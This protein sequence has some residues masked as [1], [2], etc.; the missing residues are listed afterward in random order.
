MKRWYYGVTVVVS[1]LA[2]FIVFWIMKKN[3][4]E[5]YAIFPRKMNESCENLPEGFE[6][7]QM[8]ANAI[9]NR[10][11]EYLR[12]TKGATH[13]NSVYTVNGIRAESFPEYYAGTYI[14][15]EGRLVVQIKDTYYSSN[16]KSSD[17]YSE[18]VQIVNSEAFYCH[19][20][21]YSYCE[22]VNA[23]S[24][25]TL[26]ELAKQFKAENGVMIS[27]AY[28]DDYRN[29]VVVK[30]GSQE[31]YEA[32]IEKLNS[33]IYSVSVMDGYFQDAT[34]LYPGTGVISNGVPFSVACRVKRNYPDGTF[35]QGI[36]S[37]AH[38]FSGTQIVCVNFNI[39]IG[40]SYSFNQHLGGTADVAF[41]ETNS[42]VTL[43]DYVNTS[44]VSLFSS[45]T[46][47]FNQ[48][49]IINMKGGATSGIS[50]G[51]V[52][53]SSFSVIVGNILFTDLVSTTYESTGGDS[54]GIVFVPSNITNHAYPAGI[55]KGSY[56]DGSVDYGV[57]TKLYNDLA[58]LQ[59]GT[60]TYSLY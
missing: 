24:E 15:E 28:I 2:I 32:V 55:H 3:V 54:G 19:P 43:Y 27:I 44:P 58:A 41:I 12:E 23:I 31:D 59:S 6:N 30:F 38:S 14:N 10:F 42:D 36:L 20:V 26:G 47:S 60:I 9:T 16:Y 52:L 17:W 40:T 48:G 34:G 50:G 39:P 13:D 1:L 33:D 7:Y 57:F 5:T 51:Y 4:P 29:Q 11:F 21:R 25:V 49:A 45:Y 53:N 46:T 8:E 18:F 35:T 37:C 22:L 56:Q